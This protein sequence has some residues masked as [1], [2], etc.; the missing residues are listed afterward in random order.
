MSYKL[1]FRNPNAGRQPRAH[2]VLRFLRTLRRK[3]VAYAR[4]QLCDT[5]R[6]AQRQAARFE[7]LA[8]AWNVP[9]EAMAALPVVPTLPS[10]EWVEF[11]SHLGALRPPVT[12]PKQAIA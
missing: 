1:N 6:Q 12:E 4:A 3:R 7:H 9:V 10:T 5:L 2:V 8:R 11:R